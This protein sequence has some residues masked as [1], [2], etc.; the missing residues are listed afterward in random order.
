MPHCVTCHERRRALHARCTSEC[1]TS[2]SAQKECRV[3]HGRVVP[4][5]EVADFVTM[6]APYIPCPNAII[7]RTVPHFVKC[8]SMCEDWADQLPNRHVDCVGYKP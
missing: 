3:R 1:V 6:R 2:F 8:E 7:R 4:V 5:D